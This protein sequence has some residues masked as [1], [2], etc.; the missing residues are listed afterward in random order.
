[1]VKNDKDRF[2]VRVEKARREV[3][4][5]DLRASQMDRL[6][7]TAKKDLWRALYHA[8][9]FGFSQGQEKARNELGQSTQK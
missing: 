6:F 7:M 3:G 1:M 8:F 9:L 4:N 2:E 5:Y